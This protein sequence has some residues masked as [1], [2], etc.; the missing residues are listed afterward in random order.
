MTTSPASPAGYR[1]STAYPDG[2]RGMLRLAAERRRILLTGLVL[3]LGANAAVLAQ[4]LITGRLLTEV[5]GRHGIAATLTVLIA[6][7]LSGSVLAGAG[8]Y[9][10]SRTGE[11]VVRD[12]RVR[13]GA[14]LLRMRVA[15]HDDRRAGD[16]L[17][18]ASG[19]TVML[20]SMVTS[21]PISAVT[22]AVTLVSSIVLMGLV[23]PFLLLI[24]LGA[25]LATASILAV[26]MPRVMPAAVQAQQGV[27]GLIAV[28]DRCLRAIRTVKASLAEDRETQGIATQAGIAYA[29]GRK[30][31][32]IQAT[33]NP[34]LTLGVH[35]S[36]LLV[37]G[38]GGGQVATGHLSI[39]SLIT[40]L[41]YLTTLAVPMVS[42]GQLLS[43]YKRGMASFNRVNEILSL[44]A[45]ETLPAERAAGLEGLEG[46]EGPEGPAS[47]REP[48]LVAHAAAPRGAGVTFDG[49]VFGYKDR[50]ILNGVDMQ[51]AADT[52]A[53]IVGPSGAGKSTMLALIERFYQPDRGRVLV[54]GRDVMEIPLAELRRSIAFVEQETPVL[55][56][57]VGENIAYARPDATAD[58]IADV[59]AQAGLQDLIARLPAGLDT[60]TGDAGVLM[61]GGER[62]R[63]AIARALLGRPRV[64]LLD[65]ATSQLDSRN[66]LAMRETIRNVADAGCTVISVA[67]R[68]STVVDADQIIVLAGSTVAGVGTHEEL[69]ASSEV[70]RDLVQGQLLSTGTA[71]DEEEEEEPEVLA[72][73]TEAL[74]AWR[75]AAM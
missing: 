69:L 6:V 12:L 22:G 34:A 53:A 59:V 29:G 10:V 15:D 45:E 16:L 70:Y 25:M 42:V 26:I 67:H 37:L 23:D 2:L 14:H 9:V 32:A 11:Q 33:I 66:E 68:L 8:G 44:P 30:L 5:T 58:Q 41:L 71:A 50:V 24:T 52:R 75:T 20:R 36:F 64:L 13:L 17:S 19:D 47:P 40:F 4:P 1:G 60:G 55:A 28:L 54:D 21:T 7:F 61:S 65:E 73:S 46:L 35:G 63:I 31:A 43:D 62:Q 3:I 39:A 72:A 49:V 48:D 38:V 18:R 57:T 51:V 56:G 74:S 27:G